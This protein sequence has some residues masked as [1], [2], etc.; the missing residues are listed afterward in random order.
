[1]TCQEETEQVQEDKAQA[2]DEVKEEVKVREAVVA[3]DWPQAPAA[4]VSV[5]AAG[6]R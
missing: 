3:E 2:R 5:R 4:T 1:M 6:T